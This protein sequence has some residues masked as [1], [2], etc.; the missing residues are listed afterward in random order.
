LIGAEEKDVV[1]TSGA[2]ESNNMI[3]K[4]VAR[5]HKEK[6]KH[7]IT[8]QTAS[9]L[10]WKGKKTADLGYTGTQMRPRLL[11]KAFRGRI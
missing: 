9:F 7:I 2:T 1:F 8:T 3:I 11:P 5:F 10:Q 6:K 4:G